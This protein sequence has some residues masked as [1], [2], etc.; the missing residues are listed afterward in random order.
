MKHNKSTIEKFSK[1]NSNSWI[2]V[3]EKSNYEGIIRLAWDKPAC[4]ITNIK[5]A[6]ILHP[7]ENR[8]ISIAEAL[9]LQDFP[10][11][12]IPFGSDTDKAIQIANAIPPGVSK[13]IA[14]KI[15]ERI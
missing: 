2:S 14:N 4:A 7:K 3:S 6:Q 15:I 1:I 11:W 12:Y 10:N 13:A 9:E 5:K 8:V